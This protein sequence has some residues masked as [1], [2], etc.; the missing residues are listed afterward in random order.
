MTVSQFFRISGLG[1]LIGGIAFAVHIVSR[2][3][4]T[5]GVDPATVAK[6]DLWVPINALG[7]VGAALL[8]LGLPAVSAAMARRAGVLA[9]LGVM[10]IVL[11]W[12]FF[13]LFLSLYSVLV[14]PWLAEK[15]PQLVDASAQIPTSFIIAFVAAL[16]AELLGTVLLAIPFIRGRVRP[17][18]VG[19][20]LPAAVLLTVAGDVV[21]PSGPAANLAINLLSNSGPVVLVGALGY[22][23]FRLWSEHAPADHGESE[24]SA[25]PVSAR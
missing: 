24:V 19:Y 13:G 22:L 21:A 20:V 6:H 17:R 12:M 23:G 18:S 11:A 2:S 3:L 25:S 16:G 1:V 8:L 14:M 15:A 4:V 5:A 7:A 10:L 9:V